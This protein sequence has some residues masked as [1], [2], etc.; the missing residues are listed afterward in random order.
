V[1]FSLQVTIDFVVFNFSMDFGLCL[2]SPHAFVILLIFY[3]VLVCC[4]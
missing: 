4:L 3:N 2:M 1:S